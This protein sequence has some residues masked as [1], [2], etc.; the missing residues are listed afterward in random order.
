MALPSCTVRDTTARRS[1]HIINAKHPFW[2]FDENYV[3]SLRPICHYPY[4]LLK[5]TCGLQQ[6][7]EQ[8]K[9]A[10]RAGEMIVFQKRPFWGWA[11]GPPLGPPRIDEQMNFEICSNLDHKNEPAWSGKKWALATPYQSWVMWGEA[12]QQHW[13]L[14]SFQP[15]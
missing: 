3:G 2:K 5:C 7:Y 4:P 13:T 8:N 14:T 11:C 1:V 9:H 15:K 10:S 6:K 12:C